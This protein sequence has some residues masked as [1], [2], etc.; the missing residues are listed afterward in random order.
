MSDLVFNQ[1]HNYNDIVERDFPDIEITES[2]KTKILNNFYKI[3]G[4]VRFGLG[5]FRTNEE[6]IKYKNRILSIPL[7]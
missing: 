2:L 7:P 5:L 3:R 6:I 4:S 1:I